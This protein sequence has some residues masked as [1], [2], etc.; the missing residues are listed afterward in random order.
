MAETL[1]LFLLSLILCFFT[2][3]AAQIP[4]RIIPEYAKRGTR[5]IAVLPV[6]N[7]SSDQRAAEMLR[8]K[9]VE[10]L[11]LK[12]YPRIP[13]KAI[14]DQI[15]EFSTAGGQRIDAKSF[16]ERLGMDAVLYTTLKEGRVGQG[17]IYARTVV[18]AE[19]ELRSAKTGESLWHVEYRAVYHHYG[20]SRRQLELKASQVYEP[21]IQEVLT[22]VLSTLPDGP[23]AA[24]T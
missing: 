7:S 21:A 11:Y 3:C 6:Q 15:A 1:R 4:H 18:D 10:E 2:G 9:L 16:G 24:G 22:Q 17:I 20:F 14:D 23:D 19:F 8:K 13:L 5:L 12:G